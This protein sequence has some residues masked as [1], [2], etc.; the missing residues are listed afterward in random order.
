MLKGHKFMRR[1]SNQI[2]AMACI[3]AMALVASAQTG[4]SKQQMEE[5]YTRHFAKIRE[6]LPPHSALPPLLDLTKS[7]IDDSGKDRTWEKEYTLSVREGG[8]VDPG[9]PNFL[10]STSTATT[11]FDTVGRSGSLP[12]SV[13]DGVVI[14][15][16]IA[17][18]VRISDNRELVY[19]RFL[20]KI[21]DVL[22][23]KKA[24]IR[25]GAIITAVQFGGSIRFPSGH[26]TTFIVAGS[27]FMAL[28]KKYILFIWKPHKSQQTYMTAEPF[29]IENE[30]V[31]PIQT[32]VDE[33]AYSGMP[34]DKFEARVKSAIKKNLDTN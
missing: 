18:E 11:F 34:L 27:G 16:P 6:M 3:A 1:T 19:C 20:V 28:H 21:S 7:K 4:I 13:C 23:G 17:S 30:K 14:G 8:I 15:E 25:E 9:A 26:L 12:V 31:F 32:E 24:G 2:S 29:L 22:K 10:L 33:S 5:A